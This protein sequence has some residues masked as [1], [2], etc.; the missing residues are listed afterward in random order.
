MG[1][2]GGEFWARRWRKKTAGKGAPESRRKGEEKTEASR[3][4]AGGAR[5]GR[6]RGAREKGHA[7]GDRC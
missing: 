2:A 6:E 5:K 4:G 1:A 7:G 3:E